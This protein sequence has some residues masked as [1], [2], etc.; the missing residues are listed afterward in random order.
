MEQVRAEAFSP[1]R[2]ARGR[3]AN[4]R[5]ADHRANALAPTLSEIQAAGF[6]ARRALADELNRRGIPT[7]RGGRWHYTTVVRMLKRLGLLTWGV[8]ARINNGQAKKHAADVRAKGLAPTIAEIQKAGIVSI[9]AIARE[10][11]EREIPTAQGG[12]WHPSS[13]RRLLRRLEKLKP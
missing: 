10:L 6:M 5:A 2:G 13:A 12:K 8:G 3:L 1:K 11:S 9:N 7:A 4:K